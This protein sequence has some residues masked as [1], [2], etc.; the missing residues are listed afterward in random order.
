M[1]NVTY[2]SLKLKVDKSVNAFEFN[3]KTIEVLKYL[4]IEDKRSLVMVALQNSFIDGIYND[5]ELE[6]NFNLNIIYMY[7]N[8]SFT[9]YQRADPDK[10]YDQMQSSNFIAAVI[11]HMEEDEY[12]A[13]LDYL[14][15]IKKELT[16]YRKSAGSL[17]STLINDL[18]QNAEAAKKIVD[19]FDPDRYKEVIKFAEAANGGRP[20]S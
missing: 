15:V 16:E 12:D 3:D 14:T 8:L 5:I 18:P 19:T 7:T 9:A 1:A 10:L 20:I 17:V 6:K 4:P 2:A 11:A 13:L